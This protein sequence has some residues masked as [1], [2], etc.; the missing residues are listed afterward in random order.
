MSAVEIRWFD[1]V[2]E[3]SFNCVLR[4]KK[5]HTMSAEVKSDDQVANEVI[6][7]CQ[8][9]TRVPMG[10]T[11]LVDISKVIDFEGKDIWFNDTNNS[12]WD[13]DTNKRTPKGINP[14]EVMTGCALL[15]ANFKAIIGANTPEVFNEQ[16]EHIGYMSELDPER[17]AVGVQASLCLPEGTKVTYIYVPGTGL[18]IEKYNDAD[19]V[20]LQVNAEECIRLSTRLTSLSLLI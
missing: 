1:K 3:P 9:F 13:K 15:K 20:A 10:V 11:T 16:G 2:V 12:T 8:A 6:V 14:T 17:Y 19:K 4:D 5:G 7:I 18:T